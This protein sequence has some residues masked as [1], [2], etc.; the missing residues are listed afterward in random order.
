MAAPSLSVLLDGLPP[1]PIHAGDA[2]TTR[3]ELLARVATIAAHVT[4]AGVVPLPEPATLDGAV[5]LVQFTSGN[6]SR[7]CWRR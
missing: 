3:A 4:A 6:E 7:R 5:A 1:V 2:E